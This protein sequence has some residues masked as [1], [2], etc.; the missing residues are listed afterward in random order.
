[1]A[2]GTYAY[3]RHDYTEAEQDFSN[4][5]KVAEKFEEG[6]NRL[7]KTLNNLAAVYREQGERPEE[8]EKLYQRA[9]GVL[10]RGGDSKKPDG[11]IIH[12][13]LLSYAKFLRN[14]NRVPEAGDVPCLVE[15]GDPGL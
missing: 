3:Q 10:E 9:I 7:A 13:C 11:I 8:A 5:L 6:D 1:M 12:D 15:I 14:N 2:Q 4:A